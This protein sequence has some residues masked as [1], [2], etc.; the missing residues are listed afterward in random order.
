[1]T[2]SEFSLIDYY[3]KS[4]GV[5]RD[6]VTLGVGDDA[7]LTRVPDGNQ[8]VTS[9]DTLVGGIHFPE[10]TPPYSIGYKSLAVNLSDM[11]AMGAE[12]AWVTLSL[13]LPKI[14]ED[15][16]QQFCDGFYQLAEQF[17]VQLIG[18]DTTQGPMSI[19]VQAMG[20]VPVGTALTRNGAQQGDVIFVSGSLGE[21]AAGLSIA[22]DSKRRDDLLSEEQKYLLQRLRQPSPRVELGIKLQGIATAAI[23]IS[24]GLAADLHHILEASKVGATI[25]RNSLSQSSH[26][27]FSEDLNQSLQW[28]LHGGDDYELCFTTAE[29]N[30]STVNSI[31]RQLGLTVTEIGKIENQNGLRLLDENANEEI[32]PIGYVHF[33]KP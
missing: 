22:L 24:D 31:A 2:H 17:N 11:A 29:G 5:Q 28:V 7:A 15:W 18:G 33:S 21:A 27:V 25:N 13:T 19:T 1:M 23:D 30:R 20:F 3:F 16:I 8:L 6:D 4:R 9:V 32:L 12:P 14:N 10:D 26:S